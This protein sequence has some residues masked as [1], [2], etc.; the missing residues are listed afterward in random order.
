MDIFTP[1]SITINSLNTN[2]NDTIEIKNLIKNIKKDPELN[3]NIN[4]EEILNTIQDEKTDYL[5]NKTIKS[6]NKEV[7][8]SIQ[9]LNLSEERTK[10]LCEKLMDYRLVNDIHELHKGKIV[11]TINININNDSLYLP[12]IHVKGK[13]LNIKFLDNG[14]HVVCIHFPQR[15]LQYKFDHFLTFQ[16][17][18]DEEQ[19][20][21]SAYEYI[22]NNK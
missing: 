12:K 11:K 19:M 6:I 8:D 3:K 21:L 14:I 13:V 4:I 17:L 18:S 10:D 15:F 9:S 5:D 2:C 22:Q 1:V 16:K 7:F 20:I